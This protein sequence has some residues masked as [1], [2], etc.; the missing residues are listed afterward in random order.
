MCVVWLSAGLPGVEIVK[1]CRRGFCRFVFY[2]FF[3]A[4]VLDFYFITRKTGIRNGVLIVF[5]LIFYA[6]GEPVWVCLLVGYSLLNYI[7]GLLIE[8]F[9]ENRSKSDLGAFTYY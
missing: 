5:S 8:R 2:L 4:V 6:W 7:T 3:S 1:E 9:R